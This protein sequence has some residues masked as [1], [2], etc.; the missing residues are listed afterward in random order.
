MIPTPSNWRRR[1]EIRAI[2]LLTVAALAL[3]VLSNGGLGL[4]AEAATIQSKI[5]LV[6]PRALLPTPEMPIISM[7]IR[8]WNISPD[9][10]SDADM[11]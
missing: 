7:M 1:H 9:P 8:A 3:A 11:T 5:T 4:T 6:V 10:L 2:L